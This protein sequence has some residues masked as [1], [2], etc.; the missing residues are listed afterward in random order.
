M[1]QM[2]S[3][4]LLV[5]LLPLTLGCGKEKEL[6]LAG[7]WRFMLDTNDQGIQQEWY[8]RELESVI[9]LPGSL[10]AQ[11]FG[12]DVDVNTPWTGQIVD[13][14][15]YNAPQYAKYREKGNIKVPFWLNPEKHYVGVAWYQKEIDIPS[16]WR[17][18]VVFLN[19]ER[20]HWQT[21]LY[22]DGEAVGSNNSLGTSHVYELKGVEPGKHTLTL[23]VDNRMVIPVGINAHSMSDHTQTNWN[24]IIGNL[25]MTAK[26]RIYIDKIAIF[27]RVREKNVEII[28]TVINKTEVSEEGTLNVTACAGG[29]GKDVP[30]KSE[31]VTIKPGSNR[32]VL[33]LPMGDEPLLWDEYTP[34]LYRLEAQ[35]TGSG[36]DSRKADHFGMRNLGAENRRFTVNGTPVFLRGTLECSIFPLTGY[37]AMDREY[38]TKIY[39]A[40]K[41]HGLNHVRFHSWCP[42]KAAF[43]VADS[44]GVYLQVE[45][46]GWTTVGSGNSFDE[47]VYAEGDRILE[48][49]GN[50]PS[51][52]A[53]LYGNEPGGN[54]APF[55]GKLNQHWRES[56]GRHLY[57]GA[58]GW[59]YV[60]TADFY[61][62]PDP[63]IQGWGAGL[64]S[65]INARP[66]QTAYDF[67]DIIRRTTMPTVSH[68][69]GQ[70]CAYPNFKEIEK[71]TGFL[72]A[73][74]F[75]IFRATLQENHMEVMA[76][77]FLMAS[78]KLQTLCYKADIEAALRTPEFAG[79]QLL[80]LHDFPGQGTALVGVLDPFWD[81]K[82]Y[83]TPEEYRMFC[84]RTVPLA[85]MDKMTWSAN[86]T[87]KADIEVSHFEKEAAKGATVEWVVVD[88]ANRTYRKGTFKTDLPV[89]NCIPVG[90]IEIP[91]SDVTDARQF[92]L[93]V[94]I[95]GK[96]AVNEWNFWV[97]PEVPAEPGTV[98]MTSKLDKEA[99][100][101]L[102]RG[103]NVM[104]SLERGSVKKEMGGDIAVGF[105]SIFWNTAWTAKQAPHTLG[106]YCNP[107]HPALAGF[108]TDNHSDYQ[109]WDIVSYC[110]AMV[111]DRMPPELTPVISLIDDWF[112][113]RRLAIAYEAKVGKGRILVTSIDFNNNIENRLAARQ[114]KNSLLSYMNSG[115][116][117]P[118]VEL[119]AA[120]IQ[121]QI[122][123]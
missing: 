57:S 70:W 74:N 12:N 29:R 38:W 4:L 95:P 52:F 113:N 99:V 20:A 88:R 107:A 75:E 10:Q 7:E 15:W 56:D 49:Y 63:R 77:P 6:S 31:S 123:L 16:R 5:F 71:Y 116:F 97:Y 80:D 43:E 30:A 11:G 26:P 86:E 3:Y 60:E 46:G 110:D 72:K 108:P 24:G 96:N 28:A 69:I 25:S 119:S 81:S 111:I 42:P 45:C 19:L 13:H 104:L 8:N 100:E 65:L 44:M 41:E 2:M 39:H 50:H 61:N 94:S 73:K 1:K 48:E 109:W 93:R 53:L 36:M 67:R 92:T 14:S 34:N 32:I 58:A 85:R 117:N 62:S 102:N 122:K 66:P 37:P 84:N 51:F 35:L 79:F 112:T 59:P 40:V 78:G 22:L 89:T 115:D 101:R 23:R 87:F 118:P 98:Y 54:S 55:F 120:Q 91:L 64:H 33:T 68:E 114:L 105:S 9:T 121:E 27:P 82:G 18:D 21:T 47:W 103:E 17:D 76:E 106:I 90:T 83:V